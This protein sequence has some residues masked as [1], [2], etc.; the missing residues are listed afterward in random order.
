MKF[1]FIFFLIASSIYAQNPSGI[2]KKGS[3]VVDISA[4]SRNNEGAAFIAGV[5][6]FQDVDFQV[7]TIADPLLEATNTS[8]LSFRANY[9]V[10]KWFSLGVEGIWSQHTLSRISVIETDL[11]GTSQSGAIA[12]QATRPGGGLRMSLHMGHNH[13]YL[14]PYLTGTLGLR[15]INLQHISSDTFDV[16]GFHDATLPWLRAG[17]GLR[18]ITPYGIGGNLEAALGGPLL[19]A[20]LSYK[21]P[22]GE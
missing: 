13:P 5:I 21:I 8:P 7:N 1:V 11:S 17:I 20:G 12:L 22:T 18:F 2:N 15:R 9:R 6:V 10:V 16:S 4:G 19:S 14:D 3:L